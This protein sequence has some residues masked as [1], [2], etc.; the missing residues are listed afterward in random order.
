MAVLAK[1]GVNEIEF[2]YTTPGL[3][4]GVIITVFSAFIFAAYLL[5]IKAYRKRHPAV[6]GGEWPEGEELAEY[7]AENPEVEYVP[8]V[9]EDSEIELS[10]FSEEPE[11]DET[12]ID[13]DA[14]QKFIGDT[15]N[16]EDIIETENAE[17][18]G[19]ED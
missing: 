13:I 3:S 11:R 1:S 12:Y 2:R 4:V 16:I 8:K 6:Y 14:V 17:D 10:S 18:D 5:I 9:K 15:E 19:N 7:F